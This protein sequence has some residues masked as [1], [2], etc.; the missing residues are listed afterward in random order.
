MKNLVILILALFLSSSLLFGQV[1]DVNKNVEKDKAAKS[2]KSSS[3][4]ATSSSGSSGSGYADFL[5]SVLFNSIGAAQMAAL[6]NR[7]A[8]PKRMALEAYGTYGTEFDTD[9]LLVKTGIRGTWGIFGTDFRYNHLSDHTGKLKEIEWQVILLRLPIRNVIIDYGFGYIQLPE[10]DISYFNNGFSL[11]V[12]LDQ[13]GITITTGY[14]W[15]QTTNLGSRYK[16]NF[17][18]A[19]SF[20]VVNARA[21]H[22]S[23]MLSYNYLNYFEETSFSVFSVGLVVGLY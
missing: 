16:K 15:A 11:E 4:S 6:E 2:T 8:Y 13:P 14:R 20:N 21:F 23:P 1:G 19:I 9:A 10:N 5:G 3:D 12:W 18:A 17:E 22:L 7:Q